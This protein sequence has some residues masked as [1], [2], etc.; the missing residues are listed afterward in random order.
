MSADARLAI[1]AR[2]RQA[3]IRA[4]I[5]ETRAG[6]PAQLAYPVSTPASRRAR[7]LEEFNLLGVEAFVEPDAASVRNRVRGMLAGKTILSWDAECLP[8]GVGEA[9][10]GEQV[11]YGNDP[12]AEQGKA[13]YGIT[14]CE[15]ALAET[16]SLA[17]V[18]GPGKPRSAS[19]MPETHI[20]VIREQGILLGMGEFFARYRE[21]PVLPYVVFIT[22]PSRTADIELSLTL[23][24][25]GPGRVVAVIGP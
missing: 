17:M 25:H 9:L 18:S 21:S 14:G 3:Q 13:E 22:G 6:M 24:V 7:L 15:S 2:V 16:G 1:L 20:V 23:G 19:L 10:R 12:K 11:Y 5:P 4:Y 8:Y